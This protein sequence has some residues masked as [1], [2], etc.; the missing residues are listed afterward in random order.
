MGIF[1]TTTKQLLQKTPL[2]EH[3]PAHAE[4]FFNKTHTLDLLSRFFFECFASWSLKTKT[5]QTNCPQKNLEIVRPC[6]C[7][8][9]FQNKN[10]Q[11]FIKN[12]HR[13]PSFCY[14]VL[15]LFST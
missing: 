14:R 1:K 8:K 15:G 6:P 10:K 11:N 4:N 12:K 7:R 2:D 9:P 5:P 13:F 3:L